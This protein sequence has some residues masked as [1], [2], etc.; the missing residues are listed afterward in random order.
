MPAKVI[1]ICGEKRSG[2]DVLA[3]YIAHKYGYTKL[4]F[5]DPLK[6]IVKLI[7]DFNDI[8]VGID[9]INCNGTEKDTIDERWGISPRQA[10]QFFGT[11]IFQNNIQQ[12]IPNIN[13]DFF[14]NSLINKIKDNHT[15]VISDI[16]F[17]HEYEKLKNYDLTI[18]RISRPT[19]FFNTD[20][21]LS[22]QEFKKLPFDIH[23]INDST[24]QK[25]FHKYNLFHLRVLK[26]KY[27]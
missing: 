24:I 10:L 26:T 5:A 11:E 23:I 13:K 9:E 15:Y 18:I 6:N 12:L 8:Q 16:R 7:F 27:K 19:N 22:E 4:A 17:L 2:K 3:N 21:H 20:N 25:Y 1:A 14:A